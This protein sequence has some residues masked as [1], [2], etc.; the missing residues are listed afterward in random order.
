ML[1]ASILA[2]IAFSAAASAIYILN[3]IIDL[4]LDRQHTRKRS[5]PFASGAL[6][7]PFGLKVSALLLLI[8]AAICFSCRQLLLWLSVFI[9]LRR[10]PIRWC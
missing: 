1:L 8:A 5:R 6:S 2:F 9:W 10:L 4:P 3:D 7:I